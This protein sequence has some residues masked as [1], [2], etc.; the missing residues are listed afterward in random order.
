MLPSSVAAADRSPALA[1][2]RQL[3]TIFDTNLCSNGAK[4]TLATVPAPVPARARAPEASAIRGKRLVVSREGTMC[5]AGE[6]CVNP[7]K[8]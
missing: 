1:N 3:C 6:Q 4:V 8:A 5:Y 2:R 7:K